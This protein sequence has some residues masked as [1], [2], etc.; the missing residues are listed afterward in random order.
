MPGLGGVPDTGLGGDWAEVTQGAPAGHAAAGQLGG[1]SG[2]AEG[3][4]TPHEKGKT[5]PNTQ[6]PPKHL[7]VW[8]EVPGARRA[9]PESG[10][11]A[12]TYTVPPRDTQE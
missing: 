5:V 10:P 12:L 8:P 4:E 11:R 6:L 7:P 3:S 2:G 9:V 1:T